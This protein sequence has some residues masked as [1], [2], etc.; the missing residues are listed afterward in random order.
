GFSN[1]YLT[2]MEMSILVVPLVPTMSAE[3]IA[4]EIIAWREG[5]PSFNL[6]YLYTNFAR[7]TNHHRNTK[8][9]LQLLSIAGFLIR[10]KVEVKDFNI[11]TNP[12]SAKKSNSVCYFLN[13]L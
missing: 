7:S 9:F 4:N 1:S 8:E 5:D 13:T 10:D 3:E 12:V 11:S 6:N 2:E